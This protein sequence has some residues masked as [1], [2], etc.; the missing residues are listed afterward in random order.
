MKNKFKIIIPSYN[1]EDWVE[2]NIAS[3]LNQNYSN[4]EVLYINDK[5]TDNTFNK[6]K[7][8]VNE[9]DNWT[10][11]NNKENKGAQYNYFEHLNTFLTD[12]KDILIHLDGDDWLY[13]DN[14]LDNLNKFYC[15]KDCW[16]TYG[17]FVCW[18]GSEDVKLPNPQS[19]PY[20]EFI[21]KYKM[22]RKDVWRASHLRT[23]RSFL[24]KSV[25]N[26]DLKSNI[27]GK[28]YWHAADL[29]HQFPCL[30]MCPKDK[31]GVVD[32]YTHC[33]NASQQ[34]SIRTREREDS[35]N[36]KYE[37]EIRNKKI[38]KEGLKGEKLPQVNIFGSPSGGELCSIPTEFSY[39]YNVY[40]GEYDLVLLNDMD[41]EKYLDGEYQI[42]NNVPIVARLLEQRDY[43]Q[44]KLMNKVKENYHKFHTILTFD[45]I[46]LDT[47]PNARFCNAEGI[48]AFSV[49]PNTMNIPSYY[50]KI[51]GEFNVSK[52]IQM[53][54]KN[55][56]NRAVCITSAKAFLPGHNVRLNFVKN[57]KDKIDLFGKGIKEVESKLDVLHNYAFSLA[58]ENNISKDD[59]YFTEKLIEC[60]ITG[61]IPIYYGCPNIDK[62]FDIKGILTFNT[63]K[64]LDDILDNLNEEKY[65]SMLK[66]AKANYNKAIKE[67]V[68]DNDSL[69]KLHLKNII[70]DGTTV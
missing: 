70:K 50:P 7:D 66:Y 65:N 5:S 38:Y 16:M 10:I 47:L 4:Y 68:L 52:T 45:K 56:F 21:H 28:Y 31:I 14:V 35:N 58:I 22:Y 40:K 61:T 24:I 57:S 53:F 33:Y 32:F 15:E 13:D 42:G 39:C 67:F 9:L 48:T 20:P 6:V 17:G 25:K 54:P 55:N 64:E 27:D 60:I 23:F 2:Y 46:L 63:Q 30:E 1:N 44:G 59:Y 43:F 34:N 8:I 18:D 62:F 41:I 3:I 51:T 26:S 11:I 37:E 36:Q 29:A 12:D 19:T 69:Y 49:F